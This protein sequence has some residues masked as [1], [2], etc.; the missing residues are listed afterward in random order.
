MTAPS[1]A[2][3]DEDDKNAGKRP[4][5]TCIR[6]MNVGRSQS[7]DERVEPQVAELL[8]ERAD[9]LAAGGRPVAIERKIFRMNKD[10]IVSSMET[11]CDRRCRRSVESFLQDFLQ[12]AALGFSIALHTYDASRGAFRPWAR[13]NIMSELIRA[14]RSTPTVAVPPKS[15]RARRMALSKMNG[16]DLSPAD[17]QEVA[18]ACRVSPGFVDRLAK[19]PLPKTE[20]LDA[21]QSE[22]DRGS[23]SAEDVVFETEAM[24]AIASV[25]SSWQNEARLR[26]A[27]RSLCQRRT[28]LLQ[29][30]TKAKDTRS[31]H[32]HRAIA[33][34]FWP[35]SPD[36]RLRV[37]A[38]LEGAIAA[39]Y[40]TANQRRAIDIECWRRHH[41]DGESWTAIGASLGVTRVRVQSRAKRGEHLIA[42]ALGA[43]G[44]APEVDA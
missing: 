32:D 24:A 40:Q 14:A 29:A 9:I 7:A 19:M 15:L 34:C 44:G 41:V 2:Q 37:L 4:R 26:T 12:A 27:A 42:A 39:A 25:S 35:D 28:E 11:I 1:T 43:A 33:E 20:H 22:P 38:T 30:A 16:A 10:L 6:L 23:A 3:K 8:R 13:L 18:D 5:R 21:A 31:A 17:L 36:D